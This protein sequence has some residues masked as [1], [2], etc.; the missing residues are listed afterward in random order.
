MPPRSTRTHLRHSPCVPPEVQPD[1]RLRTPGSQ[2]QSDDVFSVLFSPYHFHSL[3][4]S[5][6]RMITSPV[7]V[8]VNPQH[9]RNYGVL[10]VATL[11]ACYGF[12]PQEPINSKISA[13]DCSSDLKLVVQSIAFSGQFIMMSV[14][15]LLYA[16]KCAYG[17]FH[18]KQD[19]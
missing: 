3:L 19:A 12:S 7:R 9:G 14:F 4:S 10:R 18:F 6:P 2:S 11:E 13:S 5:F 1:L 17:R 15:L 16:A 8:A